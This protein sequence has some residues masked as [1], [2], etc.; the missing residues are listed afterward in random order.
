MIKRLIFTTSLLSV[1]IHGQ[2]QIKWPEVNAVTKPWTRW[3]WMGSAVNPK[4]L[5]ANMEQYAAVGLGGLEI[6]PIYGVGG[7]ESKF[8]DY[9]SPHWMQVF[10][11]T[12]SE[13]K[14]LNMQID[15]ATGSGWPFGGGP[16]IGDAEACKNFV[17]KTWTLKAGETVK[18][19]ITFEQQPYIEAI[20]NTLTEVNNVYPKNAEGEA[21][22]KVLKASEKVKDVSTLAEPV[23]ANKNL[24]AL[25]IDQL[26]Y[27]KNLPVQVVMAYGD[28]GQAIDITANVGTNGNLN[29]KAPAGNWTVYALFMG[30]HGKMVERAAPGA[31]GNAIDHFSEAALKK[32]LSRFDTAFAGNDLSQLR[33][34]FNDSYEVDD[35]RGQSNYTPGFFTE[36][37]ARRG[38][39]LK[40]FLPQLLAKQRD[41]LSLRILYDYRQTI[42]D[43]LLDKFTIPWRQWA[44]SKG[45]IV[46]NQSHGSPAN[47]LDCYGVVDIPETEGTELL[48]FKF[49]V[50]AA[51]I[52]GKPLASAEAAT[53]LNEHFKTSL[54]DVKTA[55]DKY[56][57]G[58][59]NHIVYHGTAYSPM[60][61]QWPGWLFYAAVHFQPIHPFWQHFGTLNNYVTR[62]QSFL[63]SGK[64][65]NDV[66]LYFPFSDHN[67]EPGRDL[68]HHYDGMKGF[69]NTDFNKVAEELLQKGYAFDFISDKQLEQVTMNG[70]LLKAPGGNYRTIVLANTKYLP[71]TTWQKLA[72]LAKDGARIIVY[73]NL[74]GGV[75]GYSQ[76]ETRQKQFA[77]ITAALKFS[78]EGAL[79]KAITGKGMFIKGDDIGQ[80]LTAGEVK[81]EP[82]YELGLQCIRRKLID[83]NYYFISNTSNEA[84][85][86]WVPLGRKATSAIVFEPMQQESGI[87]RTRIVKGV[88]EVYV[89]LQ[90]G[91]S[92]VL[93]TSGTTLKGNAYKYYNIGGS[94]SEIKGTWTLRFMMGGPDLPKTATMTKLASWTE[95]PDP[96]GKVFSGTAQYSI[97]FAKP[98]GTAPAYA[99]DLGKVAHSAEVVLNGKSLATVLGPIYRVT[100][101][102]SQLKADNV[103]EVNVTNGM[104]NR[105]IALEQEGVSWKK[106]YNVNFPARLPE[107]RDANGLFT[108]AKWQP[109]TSGLLGP[110]TITP[111]K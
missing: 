43:L 10:S 50:S 28:K 20:G 83:G 7:Y 53:W 58:G 16:L 63:Q 8:I 82:M 51:H 91:E 24:Q 57:I 98:A 45:K 64:P 44:Q 48:R 17:Y 31:E 25:A 85:N 5:T 18:E 62:C 105:I 61:D 96:L 22:V 14:R 40:L 84:V 6:T 15:M 54:G 75:P 47:I 66:L 87:A 36:F 80:L 37:K 95:V 88:T 23:Y 72:A 12:L 70:A 1:L 30:W 60:N 77:D 108:A 78:A 94:A 86:K 90:P 102:A 104:T 27:K 39:D 49:A 46:R 41:E 89:Q 103:L 4:D 111:L 67:S 13:A 42:A 35:A 33:G 101:P 52:L 81:P 73:K 19:P 110:V 99:L 74:P 65:D 107:N 71:L 59:V 34:F 79:Q 11:H 3:W 29:W 109:E 56:F 68:L 106:F 93:Q 92:C 55:I 38:Y 21:V 76:L 100:I 32:Y 9:L 2:A 97:H 26:K 69:E